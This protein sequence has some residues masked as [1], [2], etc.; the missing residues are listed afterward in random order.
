M[1]TIPKTTGETIASNLHASQIIS[2]RD[3]ERVAKQIN[4]GQAPL[5]KALEEAEETF[6]K[7]R[8]LKYAMVS[9][10]GHELIIPA[11]KTVRLALHDELT[12]AFKP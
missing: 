1:P 4:A 6:T 2:G 3:V 7:L 10:R 9:I 8:D 5:I 11:L 12:G